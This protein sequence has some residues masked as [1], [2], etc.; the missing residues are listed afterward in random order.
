MAGLE[1]KLRNFLQRLNSKI[2]ELDE[3]P[4]N[5]YYTIEEGE[6]GHHEKVELGELKTSFAKKLG[7]TKEY[8]ELKTTLEGN[9]QLEKILENAYTDIGGIIRTIILTYL[10]EKKDLQDAEFDQEAFSKVNDY[11]D[12]FV[13]N[14]KSEIEF[15]SVYSR[16][17]Y[18]GPTV[19]KDEVKISKIS[20]KQR[21]KILHHRKIRGNNEPEEFLLPD[22]DQ[23]V[24]IASLEVDYEDPY[25]AFEK[26]AEHK[27]NKIESVFRLYFEKEYL[28]RRGTYIQIQNPFLNK[29]NFP[30]SL[31]VSTSENIFFGKNKLSEEELRDFKEFWEEYEDYLE[32]DNNEKIS[33]A[34]KWLNNLQDDQTGRLINYFIISELT[35]GSGPGRLN[36]EQAA[37][38]LLD[39]ERKYDSSRVNKFFSQLR[40]KRNKIMHNGEMISSS[41]DYNKIDERISSNQFLSETHSN[42]CGVIKNY[43]KLLEEA[44]HDSLGKLNNEISED[45]TKKIIDDS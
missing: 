15:F 35:L 26:K 19:N 1:P 45:I 5:E 7:P 13:R 3:I 32:S 8:Q 28:H 43:I 40:N 10:S 38:Y 31:N 39:D 17:N 21:R 41:T 44:D 37:V 34:I 25:I 24:I 11:L 4:R 14:Q 33:K 42:I 29:L 23:L 2:N 20:E 9:D 18:S 6:L 27:I 36:E 22:S 30:S 16:T 12:N